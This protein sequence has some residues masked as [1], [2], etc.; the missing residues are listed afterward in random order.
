MAAFIMNPMEEARL[1]KISLA[2]GA[3]YA[4]APRQYI[5]DKAWENAI[6]VQYGS[7]AP[8]MH[9]FADHSQRMENSWAHTGRDDAGQL[10]KHLDRYLQ[11]FQQGE[12][13]DLS[14]AL[15]RDDFAVM[16]KA[17]C[18]LAGGLSPEV[19][20]E[21]RS[22]LHRLYALA[23]AD[24][25]ALAMLQSQAAGQKHASEYLRGRLLWQQQHLAAKNIQLSEKTAEKFIAEALALTAEKVARDEGERNMG[26]K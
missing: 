11:L 17:A 6:Q 1:S 13:T 24:E 20:A 2:T 5:P 18:T 3:E 22:Q 4:A 10:R 26:R 8:A 25:T 12:D 7:L 19:K 21:C 23:V 9:T 15:L 16:K 14:A